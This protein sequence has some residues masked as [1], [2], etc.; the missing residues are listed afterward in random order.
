MSSR[1]PQWEL[2]DSHSDGLTLN[3]D[4]WVVN[5]SGIQ[6]KLAAKID[7]YASTF[8]GDGVPRPHP[9]FQ[10]SE[11]TWLNVQQVAAPQ[12]SYFHVAMALRGEELTRLWRSESS[13]LA[14]RVFVWSEHEQTWI[15]MHE[16]APSA[17]KVAAG[18]PAQSTYEGGVA[19]G[20]LARSRLFTRPHSWFAGG[21]GAAVL[22]ISVVTLHRHLGSAKSIPASVGKANAA[23]IFDTER[24]S[25]SSDEKRPHHSDSSPGRTMDVIPVTA[26]PLVE[27][28]G[29]ITRLT[30]L[31]LV[32]ALGAATQDSHATAHNP[33]RAA[34]P[35]VTLAKS[36]D[37]QRARQVLDAASSR[38]TRCTGSSPLSGAALV[39]FEPS[40]VVADVS[41]RSIAG[42]VSKVSCVTS[43]YRSV[44][45]P[46]FSGS[47]VT[48]KKSFQ[49]N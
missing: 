15:V 42:D 1:L 28:A 41:I 30:A 6:D 21:L 10:D 35:D 49:V 13:D 43:A 20:P 14:G 27:P 34:L 2:D 4:R 16:P 8:W 46:A 33:E 12:S 32:G 37:A 31:P 29:E 48:V 19:E 24:V 22:L 36:F 9:G 18:T 5:E 23:A 47:R 7:A 40:G 17:A 25:R 3:G 11:R 45:V 39:T 26:L 38:L 44:H